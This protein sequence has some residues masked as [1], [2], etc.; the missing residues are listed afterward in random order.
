M[1]EVMVCSAPLSALT[2]RLRNVP[3]LPVFVAVFTMLSVGI[4]LFARLSN[5][6][7]AVTLFVPVI[8]LHLH[9]D[10]A[11][12]NN[13]GVVHRLLVPPYRPPLYLFS[14][15]TRVSSAAPAKL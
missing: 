5:L 8:V 2:P 1:F 13:A 9:R 15:V 3:H 4:V 12:L 6:T 10:S 7:V 14:V 11:P